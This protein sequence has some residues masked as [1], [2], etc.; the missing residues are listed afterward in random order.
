MCVNN[1]QS[2][3][4]KSRSQ[5]RCIIVDTIAMKHVE[6]LMHL[7]T[8]N[9]VVVNHMRPGEEDSLAPFTVVLEEKTHHSYH[10]NI[11]EDK[12]KVSVGEKH[13]YKNDERMRVS[14]NNMEAVLQG[15]ATE[16]DDCV[17]IANYVISFATVISY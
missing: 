2:M 16:V 12:C 5:F 3:K 15:F 1:E 11:V 10:H 14:E 13:Q 9:G 8:S 7:L 17:S 6:L 4:I